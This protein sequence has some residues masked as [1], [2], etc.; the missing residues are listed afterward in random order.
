MAVEFEVEKKPALPTVEEAG[1]LLLSL[2][3]RDDFYH[4]NSPATRLLIEEMVLYP[5]QIGRTRQGELTTR[6]SSPN[7]PAIS[8]ENVDGAQIMITI[9][10]E[11]HWMGW[12]PQEDLVF[13]FYPDETVK[14]F[15]YPKGDREH[16]T[17]LFKEVTALEEVRDFISIRPKDPN[18]KG[19]RMTLWR[20]QGIFYSP[21]AD[22]ASHRASVLN[23][24][25][26]AKK[27][28]QP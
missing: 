28:Q 24:I 19:V 14:A 11:H 13:A 20:D 27:Y 23:F 26:F 6:E 17:G 16:R 25:N 7:S 3:K 2:F 12:G 1:A 10:M 5:L 22:F 18:A 9:T 8:R 15:R 4:L 21:V